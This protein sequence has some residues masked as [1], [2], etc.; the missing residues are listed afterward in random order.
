MR[1]EHWALNRE[2]TSAT[3]PLSHSPGLKSRFEN[4]ELWI[5]KW[6]VMSENK[7]MY[8]TQLSLGWVQG[9]RVCIVCLLGSLNKSSLIESEWSRKA[10]RKQCTENE[11][12][13]K[14]VNV[15]RFLLSSFLEAITFIIKANEKWMNGS[16]RKRKRKDLTSEWLTLRAKACQVLW[17]AWSIYYK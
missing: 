6:C 12:Q 11:K 7:R 3:L 8:E 10:K 14:L 16:C 1:G 13:Q 2:S 5:R 4:N 17:S 9:G 15:G